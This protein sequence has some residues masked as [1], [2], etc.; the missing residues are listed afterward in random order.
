MA[1]ANSNVFIAF[2][3]GINVGGH[4]L[5]NMNDLRR[6]HETM[7]HGNVATYLQSG[8]VIFECS[9]KNR[10]QLILDIEEKYEK[11][12]GFHTDIIIRNA[13]ELANIV[14]ACPFT[15]AYVMEAK[16]LHVVQLSDIPESGL[17]KKL[18]NYDGPEEKEL[19]EDVLYVY[20]T[21]G[22]GRSKLTLSLIE[23]TLKVSATARNWNTITKVLD[24]VVK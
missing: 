8:N 17:I 7:G 10:R 19:I 3:R 20:Y 14:K 5:I 24:M 2:L 4:R 23:K 18:M 21:A 6:L 11:K 15:E 13:A 1:S 22:A 16:F 12:F 9:E